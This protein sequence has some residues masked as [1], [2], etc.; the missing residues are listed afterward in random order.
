[1]LLRQLF[2]VVNAALLAFTI[3]PQAIVNLAV[4]Q[5]YKK[6]GWLRQINNLNFCLHLKAISGLSIALI[7]CP[8]QAVYMF[9]D[10]AIENFLVDSSMAFKVL[11]SVAGAASVFAFSATL[12][13]ILISAKHR[14]KAMDIGLSLRQMSDTTSGEEKLKH[15]MNEHVK[16]VWIPASLVCLIE[17]IC[18]TLKNSVDGIWKDV[19]DV[20]HG[21][22]VAIQL[23]IS[24]FAV[25]TI[26]LAVRLHSRLK[27]ELSTKQKKQ[28]QVYRI[29]MGFFA[30][31]LVPLVMI[32]IQFSVIL[33]EKSNYE[34]FNESFWY[35]RMTVVSVIQLSD[36]LLSLHW[37]KDFRGCV[38]KLWKLVAK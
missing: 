33:A 5:Q 28:L 35:T 19:A 38:R 9:C 23:P 30:F 3:L 34:E 13:H 10:F 21:C 18:H 16:L 12:G 24:V 25:Y 6:L 15:L 14:V 1:M 17:F 4:I 11:D 32:L 8:I 22:F 26:A 29:Y 20:S 2:A 31:V 7:V 27:M 37:S 36:V